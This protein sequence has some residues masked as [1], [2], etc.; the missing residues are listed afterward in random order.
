MRG[1]ALS[2]FLFLN[3]QTLLACIKCY[4][5]DKKDFFLFFFFMQAT[6]KHL[7]NFAALLYRAILA[8]LLSSARY[9]PFP[10][11]VTLLVAAVF[12]HNNN[13]NNNQ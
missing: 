13:N 11:V 3:Y 2:L 7:I 9:G 4:H 6:M 12:I 5:L 10:F 8:S 1:L